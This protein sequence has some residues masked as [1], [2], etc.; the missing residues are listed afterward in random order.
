M[1]ILIQ[2]LIGPGFRIQTGPQFGLITDANY[3]DS[4]KNEFRKTD[5]QNGN[6]SWSV[7]FGYLTNSGF[8]LDARYNAGLSD[9]Y[10]KG[11]YP[12]QTARTRAGQFSFFYQ[13]K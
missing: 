13:F 5:I 7:G 11:V 6:I 9:I 2:Y 12:G 10:P 1:P 8:G 4:D 3:E